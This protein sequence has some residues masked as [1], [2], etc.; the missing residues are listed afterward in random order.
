ME[1][2]NPSEEICNIQVLKL[3]CVIV[4]LCVLAPIRASYIETAV[5]TTFVGW[6]CWKA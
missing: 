6:F 2:L 4:S 3:K 1:I 5:S